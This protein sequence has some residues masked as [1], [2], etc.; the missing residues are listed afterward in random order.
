MMPVDGTVRRAR[1]PRTQRALP[2]VA[3][4]VRQLRFRDAER[5]VDRRNPVD[6]DQRRRVVGPHEITLVHHERARASRDGRL[7]GRVLELYLRVF[8][9]GAIRFHGRVQRRSGRSAR[10]HFL[11]RDQAARR[12]RLVASSLRSGVRRLRQIAGE[13][14]LNLL[15]RRL[16][17]TA[18]EGEEDLSLGDVV[19]FLETH[20][21][22]GAG[23]LRMHRD[24]RFGFRGADHTNLERHGL[25]DDRPDGDEHRVIAARRACG[26]WRSLF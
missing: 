19:T 5:D 13:V 1:W 6:D 7:D 18:V 15:Q 23:D 21:C 22:D 24:G 17:R 12:E 11:A 2:Q 14:C 4:E 20:R 8:D 9:G 25:R 10:L 16:E 26:L 3:F